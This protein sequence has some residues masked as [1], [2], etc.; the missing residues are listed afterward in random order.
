MSLGCTYFPNLWTNRWRF[1]AEAGYLVSALNKTIVQPSGSLGWL[2]SDEAGQG[3]LK[4][5]VVFGF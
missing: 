2:A 4:L 3:Y 5:Q 1:T